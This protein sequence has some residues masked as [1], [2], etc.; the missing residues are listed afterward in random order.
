M[1]VLLT[2]LSPYSRAF[3][4]VVLSE[5]SLP[6]PT[7]RRQGWWITRPETCP[8]SFRLPQSGGERKN[9]YEI[10]SPPIAHAP[11]APPV[12]PP[13]YPGPRGQTMLVFFAVEDTEM[14]VFLGEWVS[15]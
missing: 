15:G 6:S 9:S 11:N 5:Q 1:N 10:P 14:F 13:P 12:N 3:P 4:V 7:R 2:F 8:L